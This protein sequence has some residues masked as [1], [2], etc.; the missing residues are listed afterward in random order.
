MKLF[1]IVI[2]LL[3]C[4]ANINCWQHGFKLKLNPFLRKLG[5]TLASFSIVSS[6]YQPPV[7]AEENGMAATLQM[8]QEQQV[9]M[10][11]EMKEVILLLS[12]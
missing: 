2:S 12:T 4:I 9:T 6:G 1:K 3:L 5:V 10:Q 7:H 11:R 8:M